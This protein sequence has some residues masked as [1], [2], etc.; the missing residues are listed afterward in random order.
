MTEGLKRRRDADSGNVVQRAA[1][2]KRTG[3]VE[4]RTEMFEAVVTE[5]Y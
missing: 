5:L 2:K 1:T 4:E 3:A